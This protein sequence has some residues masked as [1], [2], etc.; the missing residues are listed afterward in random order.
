MKTRPLTP[1]AVLSCFCARCRPTLGQARGG[2]LRGDD[3]LDRTV[4][5]RVLVGVELPIVLMVLGRRLGGLE[6][7]LVELLL[8]LRA[9]LLD[10]QG[11]LLFAD[12]RALQAL[13]P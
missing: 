11:D 9:A 1:P 3:D 10:D 7:A 6:Q 13:Q 12:V 8:A 4:E 2:G 5:Q